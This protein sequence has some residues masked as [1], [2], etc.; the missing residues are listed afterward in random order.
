[1]IDIF[2]RRSRG[3]RGLICAAGTIC[4]L[5]LPAYAKCPVNETTVLIVKAETG[6]LHIDTTG[7][8]PVVDVQAEEAKL[9]ESCGKQIIQYDGT[10]AK[11]WK[12]IT[13][14]DIDLELTTVGGNIS[15]TDVDGNVVMH[16]S[17]G[18]VTVGSV[19][20]NATIITQGGSIKTGSIG[21]NAQLRTPGT[22]EVL[23]D[24][25]GNAELYT[26]A[27]KITTGNI[28]GMKAV[29]EAG[30]AIII[31]K[32]MEVQANTRQG[33]ISIGEAAR[34]SAQSGGGQIITHR[35]HGGF[36]GRT[37][38]GDIRL[39]SA[40]SWVEASTARG[41]I[42]VR[43]A[44][45]NVDGDLHMDLQ[46]GNGDLTLYVPSR[47]KASIEATVQRPAF[48]SAAIVN[49]FPAPPRR[50]SQTLIPENKYYA[51]TH[52][53]STINGGGNKILLQVS[54]GKIMIRK[55]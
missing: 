47:V 28:S 31:N 18:S 55:N 10:G 15:V 30:R 24:I 41:N 48:Q 2:S 45:E 22:I 40:G 19:R 29:V 6:D 54:V 23:G 21:G 5:V 37:E 38:L 20:G 14:R 25:G 46:T 34:I 44:P 53:E 39:D 4:G 27:G 11:S 12:I 13:P 3:L 43:M 51:P 32:A 33:D 36:H 49:E 1:M 9:H 52:T 35:V 17:G 8:E 7:R 26:T 42:L 16:T 50:P